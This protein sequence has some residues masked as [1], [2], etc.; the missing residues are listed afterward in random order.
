MMLKFLF[1]TRGMLAAL[2]TASCTAAATAEGAA[3]EAA[4]RAPAPRAAE[5]DVAGT[6]PS[7]GRAGN[8]GGG[9]RGLRKAAASGQ[10]P[11]LQAPL[12]LAE[13]PAD[14]TGCNTG[15]AGCA[16]HRRGKAVARQQVVRM[17]HGQALAEGGGCG[18][19]A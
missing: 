11:E 5:E 10:K 6:W 2:A 13:A 15:T 8:N 1:L 3:F 9:L 19:P 14:G 17:A 18:P 16:T 7:A 12:L 4:L